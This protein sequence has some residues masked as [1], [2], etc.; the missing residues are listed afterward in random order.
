MT[1]R[2]LARASGEPAAKPRSVSGAR[3]RA[4]AAAALALL[5]ACAGARRA[6]PPSSGP[7]GPEAPARRAFVVPGDGRILLAL[8]PG[9]TATEGEEGEAEVPT[10]RLEQEGARFLLLLSPL[11]NPGEPEGA[12][13]RADT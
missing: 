11:W 1:I 3:W 8:P 5:V 9:W 2:P 7:T 4:G 12:Q 6:A 13:A 10:I